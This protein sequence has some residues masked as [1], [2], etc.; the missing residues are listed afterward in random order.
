MGATLLKEEEQQQQQQQRAGGLGAGA[1]EAPS[2]SKTTVHW[3]IDASMPP[4]NV[5][6]L[7]ICS[8]PGRRGGWNLQGRG[9][10]IR[11]NE[12]GRDSERLR[13]WVRRKKRGK[14][15]TAEEQ[16]MRRYERL[17]EEVGGGGAGV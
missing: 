6:S 4:N 1:C 11:V 2:T 10:S 9:Q 5:Y 12:S 3:H 7:A 14:S 17:G 16:N 13:L 8:L 15:L